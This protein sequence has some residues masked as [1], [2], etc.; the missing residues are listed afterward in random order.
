MNAIISV[1]ELELMRDYALYRLAVG[2]TIP[3]VRR[4]IENAFNVT[5]VEISRHTGMVSNA[6]RRIA[7]RW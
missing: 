7:L 1:A 5:D 4:E 6:K 3:E 2:M